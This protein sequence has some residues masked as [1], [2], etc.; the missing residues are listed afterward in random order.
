MEVN[1]ERS[2]PTNVIDVRFSEYVAG[3]VAQTD[4]HMENGVP[5]YSYGADY[6]LRQKIKAIPGAFKLAKAIANYIVPLQKQMHN[7]NSLKVGPNQ[8]PDVYQMVVDCSRTL[9]IGIPTTFVVNDTEINAFAYATE[10]DAP[11]IGITSGLLER[12]TPGETKYVIGHECGH[13]HNNHSVFVIAAE[14]ILNTGT[15]G[16]SIALP[17]LV[18]ILQLASLPMSMAF[19]AWS[20][21]S[22]VSS[23]RA[24]IICSDNMEDVLG[25]TAKFLYGGTFNRNDIDF[26]S[27]Y[28]Q[29]EQIRKTPVRL[30]ELSGSHPAAV[31]R[32]FAAMEFMNS[33]VLYKWRPEWKQPGMNLIDKKELDMRCNKIISVSKGEKKRGKKK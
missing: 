1:M 16:G 25:A 22:E 19:S 31:R 7:L 12:Y 13:I 29:Y 28:K 11:L 26:D 9:G 27:L 15:F 6:T 21:A 32:I 18:P 33:E 2:N 10:D 4:I 23:D 3:R 8:F 30:L 17:G 20:R 24:G 5:N 14:T